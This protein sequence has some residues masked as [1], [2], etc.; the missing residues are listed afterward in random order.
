MTISNTA[1]P[2]QTAPAYVFGPFT[3]AF[4]VGEYVGVATLYLPQ[5]A[6]LRDSRDDSGG[7]SVSRCF[8]IGKL[9]PQPTEVTA[10]KARPRGDIRAW[11]AL[12]TTVMEEW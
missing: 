3:P 6:A 4:K 1:P 12:G 2:G 9:R 10:R 11:R 8:M 5:G 7:H